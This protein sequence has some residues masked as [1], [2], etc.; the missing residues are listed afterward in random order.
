MQFVKALHGSSSSKVR[1]IIEY[2]MT[3]YPDIVKLE[4]EVNF[5]FNLSLVTAEFLHDMND[6]YDLSMNLFNYIWSLLIFTKIFNHNER[7]NH[8]YFFFS[9]GI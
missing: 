4:D 3:N 8:F 1:E 7:F 6:R 9:P 2:G 5:R